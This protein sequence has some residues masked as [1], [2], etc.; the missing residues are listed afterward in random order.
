MSNSLDMAVENQQPVV[1]GS[2]WQR[3]IADPSV[4]AAW[5]V[6]LAHRIILSLIGIIFALLILPAFPHPWAEDPSFV[7]PN[8]D[9]VLWF[10]VA[11]WQ[12]WDTEHFLQ[13]AA[14]GYNAH[15]GN[16][17]FAPLFPLLTGILGRVLFGQYMLAALI[18]SN[19]AYFVV[20]IYFHKLA[21]HLFNE[22]TAHWS[23]QFLAFF[24]TAFFLLCAYTDALYLALTVAAFY[25][26]ERR[27]WL[28]VAGL[29]SLA[30]ITRL[31]GVV[32]VLP[33]LYMYGVQVRFRLTHIRREAIALVLAPLSLVAFYAYVYFIVGDHEFNKRLEQMWQVKLV[34]PWQS[35]IGGILALPQEAKGAG[36]LYDILNLSMIIIFGVLVAYGAIRKIPLTYTIYAVCTL[37]VFL[38]RQK[39]GDLWMS[40]SRY[41]L[42]LFPEFM[43]VTYLVKRRARRFGLFMLGA[44]FQTLFV[45]V[46]IL[47]K[48]IA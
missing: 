36:I 5:P 8:H 16:T 26:A 46:F 21:S 28:L 1:R 47:Y 6:F 2:L 43:L 20:L 38:T 27:R 45:I 14:Y 32:L 10:L 35:L 31:Q 44:F 48:W 29:V 34:P 4:R 18:I 41:V 33:L 37:L 7:A 42:A 25:Y 19:I 40:M 23:L 13:I 12:R 3:F 22:H 30:C 39:E 17:A 9:P 24:P 15:D 11:P